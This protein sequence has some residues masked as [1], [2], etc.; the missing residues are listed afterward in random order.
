MGLS[1][2]VK[3]PRSYNP[4]II[5][6]KSLAL[7]QRQ[8]L[9][10]TTITHYSTL[11]RHCLKRSTIEANATLPPIHTRRRLGMTHVVLHHRSQTQLP[12]QRLRQVSPYA[13]LYRGDLSEVFCQTFS[14]LPLGTPLR[15]TQDTEQRLSAGATLCTHTH[16]NV[17][18][19]HTVVHDA[20]NMMLVSRNKSAFVHTAPTHTS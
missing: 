14:S 5:Q 19:A 20:D 3:R 4:S 6:D 7:T 18:T 8:S 1:V 9:V 17:S 12:H 10:L 13:E 11:H 15:V 16:N 2:C